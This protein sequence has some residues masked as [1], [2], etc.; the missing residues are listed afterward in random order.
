MFLVFAISRHLKSHCAVFDCG[1]DFGGVDVLLCFIRFLILTFRGL[2]K[3]II[4]WLHRGHGLRLSSR[5][6]DFSS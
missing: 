4:P 1:Y 2:G 6:L 5:Y 3:I